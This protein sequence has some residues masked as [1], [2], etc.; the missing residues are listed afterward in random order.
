MSGT[1]RCSLLK[2]SK[3]LTKWEAVEILEHA[4]ECIDYVNKMIA[5]EHRPHYSW[6]LMMNTTVSTVHNLA[7]WVR[8]GKESKL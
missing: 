7:G 1:R 2:W 4:A 6:T 5:E 3:D 8:I